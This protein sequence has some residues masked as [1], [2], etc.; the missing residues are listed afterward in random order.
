MLGEC[1]SCFVQDR[2]KALQ[3]KEAG[4]GG[5]TIWDTKYLDL[6]QISDFFLVFYQ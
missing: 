2:G 5:P 4:S 1:G 6:Q 3:K